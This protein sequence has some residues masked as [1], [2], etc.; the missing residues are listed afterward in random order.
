[1]AERMQNEAIVGPQGQVLD[2]GGLAAMMAE[3]D[4]NTNVVPLVP[5]KLSPPPAGSFLFR[6][7]PGI[8]STAITLRLYHEKED[9]DANVKAKKAWERWAKRQFGP[10]FKDALALD[11]KLYEEH[12]LTR[13]TFRPVPGAQEASYTTRDPE[14]AAYI[15]MRIKEPDLAALIYEEVAPMLVEINGQAVYVVPA[16][17]AARQAMAAAAAD[18]A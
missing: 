7:K 8:R 6:T 18:G 11:R 15:R 9:L 14:I 3:D 12:G 13:I 16:D 10:K 4:R 1:M 17:D 5:R 2:P